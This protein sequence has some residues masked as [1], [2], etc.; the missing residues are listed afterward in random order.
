ME[1]GNPQNP[2]SDSVLRIPEEIG[3]G[4]YCLA[5]KDSEAADLYGFSRRFEIRQPSGVFGEGTTTKA[6]PLLQVL[7]PGSGG[8]HWRAGNMHQIKWR[9]HPGLTGTIPGTWTIT[10]LRWNPSSGY[11]VARSFVPDRYDLRQVNQGGLNWW[12]HTIDWSVPTDLANG[13]Y[14]VRV[15]GMSYQDE[16]GLNFAIGSGRTGWNLWLRE[17]KLEGMDLVAM[18]VNTGGVSGRLDFSVEVGDAVKQVTV[19]APPSTGAPLGEPVSLGY[20]QNLAD[21]LSQFDCGIPVK[22]TADSTDR[23]DETNE[24]DNEREDHLYSSMAPLEIN[25]RRSNGN[26]LYQ[27][28]VI[29]CS[30]SDNDNDVLVRIELKNCSSITRSGRVRVTHSGYWS[31]SIPGTLGGHTE[32]RWHAEEDIIS[33]DRYVGTD[34]ERIYVRKRDLRRNYRGKIVDSNIRIYFEGEFEDRA[35]NNPFNLFLDVQD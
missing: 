7:T 31:D 35:E 15:R 6:D 1:S 26:A 20:L 16:G 30:D 8:E 24:G 19:S 14:K 21:D 3:E 25:V 32:I 11:S 29:T 34:G 28:A 4:P 23:I 13:E 33:V 10:L 18:I 12:E 17:L 9:F 27:G 22:V 2:S 5:V